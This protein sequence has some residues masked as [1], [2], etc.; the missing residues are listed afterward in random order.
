MA[1]D[2]HRGFDVTKAPVMRLALVRMAEHEYRF[3]W[4]FHH[5]LLDGWSISLL[6]DNKF[7]IIIIFFWIRISI[8]IFIIKH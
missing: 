7:N 4:S 8:V 1:E 3:L 2:S 6:C 5:A